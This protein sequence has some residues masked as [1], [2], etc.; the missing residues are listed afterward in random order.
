MNSNVDEL[1]ELERILNSEDDTPVHITPQGR[2]VQVGTNTDNNAA[3]DYGMAWTGDFK[4]RDV[5]LG[6]AVNAGFEECT[7]DDFVE[8]AMVFENYLRGKA[9]KEEIAGETVEAEPEPVA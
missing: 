9:P 3:D 4:V 6:H 7:A 1:D 2:V 8:I 5:A